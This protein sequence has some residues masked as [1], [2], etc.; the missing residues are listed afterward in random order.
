MPSLHAL[1]K[2]VGK[3]TIKK[4]NNNQKKCRN[5]M[6]QNILQ[7]SHRPVGKTLQYK[8]NYFTWIIL[9]AEGN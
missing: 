9:K 4:K 3:N 2:D 8:L 5:I 6:R 7:V 1:K